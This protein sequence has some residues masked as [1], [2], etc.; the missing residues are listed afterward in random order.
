MRVFHSWRSHEFHAAR[1][2]CFLKPEK[3]PLSTH[4]EIISFPMRYTAGPVYS[5][6]AAAGMKTLVQRHQTL[7]VYM[8][9]NLGSGEAGMPQHILNHA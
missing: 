8:G 1:K 7:L 3:F 9:I 5:G 2:S 4:G 6:L